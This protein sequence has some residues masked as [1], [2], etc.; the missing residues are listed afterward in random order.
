MRW[1][2]AHHILHWADGGPTDADNLMLLCGYHHRLV[3][4][5]GWSVEPLS[6][7][8]VRPDGRTYAPR[9]EPLRDSVRMR[10]APLLA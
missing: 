4:E 9:P 1:L 5:R 10:F 3:H 7:E 8:F 6:H 2:H